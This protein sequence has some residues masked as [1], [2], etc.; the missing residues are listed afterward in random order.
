MWISEGGAIAAVLLAVEAF[1]LVAIVGAV[2]YYLIRWTHQARVQ[3]RP[4]TTTVRAF[5]ARVTLKT[6]SVSE[7]VVAPFVTV[8]A[9][10]AGAAA[11]ARRLR[12]VVSPGRRGGN[13]A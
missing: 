9:G 12:R 4:A 10:L 2:L 11:I 3:V 1:L 13:E 5:V 7:S 8:E 6:R